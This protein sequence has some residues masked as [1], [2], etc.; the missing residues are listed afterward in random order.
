MVYN[1]TLFFFETNITLHFWQNST[2]CKLTENTAP[3]PLV[4][5][6]MK[7]PEAP[8]NPAS[9]EPVD[10]TT[11]ADPRRRAIEAGESRAHDSFVQ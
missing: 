8:I 11:T 10:H 3:L 2:G 6:G 7:Q 9:D 5:A 1:S 4:A